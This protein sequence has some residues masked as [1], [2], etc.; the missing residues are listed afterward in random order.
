MNAV[1][2]LLPA[3]CLLCTGLA[4]GQTRT[5][6]DW[7]RPQEASPSHGPMELSAGLFEGYCS[8]D[9][10]NDYVRV[11]HASCLDFGG[12]TSFTVELWFRKSANGEFDMVN[13]GESA[14]GWRLYVGVKYSNP[15]DP[16]APPVLAP[17]GVGVRACNRAYQVVQN[18]FPITNNT[19]CH[20][21]LTIDRLSGD[22]TLSLH[23]ADG[24][25]RRWSTDWL[26]EE[27]PDL[28]APSCDL[29]L[30]YR[31]GESE[32]SD[33]FKGDIAEL[34]IWSVA[35]TEAQIQETLRDTL[36]PRYYA[37]ADSGLLLYYRFDRL[38]DL[39]V[40]GQGK[41]VRDLS[42]RG[43]HGVYQG[44]TVGIAERHGREL[45]KTVALLQNYPNPF[46]PTTTIHYTVCQAGHVSLSVYN[47]L[48][49]EVARL[50]GQEQS[51]GAHTVTWAATDLPSGVYYYRLRAG[52]YIHTRKM[53]LVK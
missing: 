3:L 49:E 15:L 16:W 1:R 5:V 27:S 38:E 22:A 43:N 34:R 33:W 9:G 50:V 37:T 45:P 21:A 8:F 41:D 13:K 7:G 29:G 10:L 12:L 40:G 36:P 30:A 46:N 20:L 31:A 42:V 23:R 32:K 51:A 24:S 39:G 4:P 47:T 53:V 18:T 35:R 48:G 26:L 52:E 6:E 28:N 11:P 14:C 19:W 44:I 17:S 25:S 2:M